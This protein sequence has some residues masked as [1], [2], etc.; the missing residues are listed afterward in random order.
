[1]AKQPNAIQ[2]ISWHD[3]CL[4]LLDQR[5]LPQNEVWLKYEQA[6]DVAKAISEMVVR[7]AP[8][9]GVTVAYAV[10]LAARKAW[11]DAGAHWKQAMP[12]PLMLLVGSRPTAVNLQW[13]MS[14]MTLF[15]HGLS[16]A[17]SPEKALLEE[18]KHIHQCDIEANH[19]MGELGA[20]LIEKNSRVLTHCNAGAL[21][22]GG[23][24]TALGVIRRA[25]N[26][27]V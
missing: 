26:E 2:A 21:A 3:D 24:G 12:A 10:V 13:A 20:E 1:M 22:T 27:Y 15:Y 5:V 25:F 19:M 8:A 6:D 11:N 4:Y 17:T 23:F 16:D 18:A 9:I 7:G 14:R